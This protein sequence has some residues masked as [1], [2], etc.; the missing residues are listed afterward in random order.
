MAIYDAIASSTLSSATNTVTFSSIPSTYEHLQIRAYVRG[1]RVGGGDAA[2]IRFN[3]DTGANY[4]ASRL[5]G[6][7]STAGSDGFTARTSVFLASNIPTPGYS[8]TV[9]FE[10]AI[11]EILDYASTNKNTTVRTIAGSDT[12]GSG[13]VE[14]NGGVWLNTAAVNRIDIICATNNFVAGSVFALYGLK[15][16]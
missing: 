16:A 8:A 10:A 5:Y 6:S 2:I 15:S 11:C 9:A 3:N 14:I 1:D 12:N 13:L 4:V 7:V